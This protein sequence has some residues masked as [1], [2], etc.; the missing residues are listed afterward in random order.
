MFRQNRIWISVS[1]AI[2]FVEYFIVALLP[3]LLGRA[4]D[5]LLTGESVQFIQYLA[6]CFGSFVIGVVRRRFDSR[7]FCRIWGH[8]VTHIV[9]DLIKRNVKKSKIIS[10][11]GMVRQFADFFETDLPMLVNALMDLVV[12][13]G[14]VI[15]T[16]P[17]AGTCTTVCVGLSLLM[18]Y[19]VACKIQQIETNLQRNRERIDQAVLAEDLDVIKTDYE[20][21]V[22]M[23]V[24]RSDWDALVGAV[25]TYWLMSL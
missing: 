14:M 13:V 11:S 4:V 10:R 1:Y 22:K 21:R 6:L 25:W 18:S 8:H 12:A 16:V 7:V 5:A 2:L 17:L 24:K 19:F 9:T 15:W 23:F 20:E 3:W